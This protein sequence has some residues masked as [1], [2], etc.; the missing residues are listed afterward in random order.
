[1]EAANIEVISQ[2]FRNNRDCISV[3]RPQQVKDVAHLLDN[4]VISY[5]WS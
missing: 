2:E 1:M 5:N 3:G 4:R